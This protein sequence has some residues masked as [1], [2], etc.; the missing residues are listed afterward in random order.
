MVDMNLDVIQPQKLVHASFDH[1]T[2]MWL[3]GGKIKLD[4]KTK[5]P[6][7]LTSWKNNQDP[8]MGLFSLELDPEG[9]TSYLILWNKPEE[10]WTSG[11]WNGH[12]F[13]LVP[14][15]RL[16]YLYNFSFVT[17]ENESYFTY[18][19]YNSSV[20]SRGW[21][22]NSRGWIMLL[23]WSQPRQQCEVYAFCGAFGSCTENSMP[24]CNCLTGFV[25]K[26][27]FDWNLVDYSGGCK[28]KTKLQCENS[29]PF[30]GDKDRECEAICLNNCSC[31][32]YAFDSNGCSIWFANLLN[33]QQLSADDSSGETLYVKLA[34]SEFHDSKNSNATIIGVAV[35]VVVCIEILLTI[36]LF[37]VIRQRKRMFGAGK[38]VEGLLVA[39]GYRDLQNATR[40]FFEKLGG[41]GFGSVFKGTLGDSSVIAVKKLESIS[42][43]EKQF[44]T[45]VSTIG[46]VQH[47][48]LV[49]LRGFCSEGAKR[50][51][52]YD[53]IP[54][55]SLDFHLF[56]NKNSKPENILLDAEFC[57]KVADFG[58]AKL[59][60]RDFSRVLATIRGRRGYLAPE[61]ISGMGI[62]AKADVYSYGMMLFEFVSG[63]RNSEP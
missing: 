20:I 10:Y 61:W 4:N 46:T 43:G 48:N 22:S 29:N 17:N 31:T 57:P 24:Y 40:N 62:I 42:Q 32:A 2:D 1:P 14:K 39:F 38:P 28:R 23:F 60:G 56:H 13:S 58:L 45:E 49:R 41:G 44:R 30:N 36:L 6:Q 15:M 35:G 12:I 21:S 34:A 55:G 59:V 8:A 51:L 11:A 25:P 19:M 18:S 3:P 9:S 53:Y 63:R 52:V 26:S 7:Y 47:V 50:L 5:K 27:P 16:N 37:F 33:L 54:K